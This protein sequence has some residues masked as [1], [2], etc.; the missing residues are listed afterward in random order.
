MIITNAM[1]LWLYVMPKKK[2]P[3]LIYTMDDLE[4]VLMAQFYCILVKM[5]SSLEL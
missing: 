4:M 3:L 2:I 1:H 5:T